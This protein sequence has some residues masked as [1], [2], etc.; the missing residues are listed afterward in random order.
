MLDEI[1][2]NILSQK[3]PL[4][5]PIEVIQDTESIQKLA[6]LQESYIQLL[7]EKTQADLQ[8]L[9]YEHTRNLLAEAEQDNEDLKAKLE[10]AEFTVK[11]LE[12]ELQVEKKKTWWD[13]LRGK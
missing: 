6:K 12:E 13:K 1:A 4:I 9:T 7:N 11:K 8:L 2:Q 3:Y 5:Q 10:A